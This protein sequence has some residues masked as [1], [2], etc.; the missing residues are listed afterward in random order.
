MRLG[1]P[2]GSSE[3]QE[4]TQ[5]AAYATTAQEFGAGQNGP[6]VVV[7]DL[8]ANLSEADITALQVRWGSRS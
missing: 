8:P 5:Y 7:V 6:L 4:S 2:D 1:L 3:P